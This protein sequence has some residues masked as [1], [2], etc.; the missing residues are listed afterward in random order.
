MV[1]Y[2]SPSMYVL[3]F[4]SRLVVLGRKRHPGCVKLVVSFIR[5]VRIYASHARLAYKMWVKVI[6][7]WANLFSLLTSAIDAV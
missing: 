1:S 5:D 3:H 4:T 6:R 7:F 2:P